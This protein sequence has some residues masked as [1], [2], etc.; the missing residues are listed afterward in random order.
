[1]I[2]TRRD[3]LPQLSSTRIGCGARMRAVILP[4]HR[5]WAVVGSRKCFESWGLDLH[6]GWH[7]ACISQAVWV[8]QLHWVLVSRKVLECV[9]KLLGNK[10]RGSLG[11]SSL[12][13]SQ[14]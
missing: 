3:L 11:S 9:A 2:S 4:K 13:L 1:M 8:R 12:R 5:S 7:V 14:Y 6:A 10:K